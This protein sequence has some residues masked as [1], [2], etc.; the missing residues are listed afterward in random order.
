VVAGPPEAGLHLVGDYQAAG[1]TNGLVHL[2]Q[3]SIGHDDDA[4]APHNR[5]VD[6]RAHAPGGGDDLLDF[7]GVPAVDTCLHIY[8]YVFITLFSL[9]FCP[10]RYA[11][12]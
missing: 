6:E 5:L 2:G 12:C 9:V 3:V 1:V 8:L 10:P 7:L 4:A 11:Y